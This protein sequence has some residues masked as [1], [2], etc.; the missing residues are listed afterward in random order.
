MKSGLLL[1]LAMALLLSSMN[2][3]ERYHYVEAWNAENLI[4]LHVAAHSDQAEDQEVKLKVKD[5]VV[6]ELSPALSEME[7]VREARV[8][9]SGYVASLEQNLQQMPELSGRAVQVRL[10]TEW[11]PH[12]RYGDIALPQG[13]YYALRVDIGQAQGANWWCLLFP[14]LCLVDAAVDYEMLPPNPGV[15]LVSEDEIERVPTRLRWAIW[16]YLQGL[17][18]WSSGRKP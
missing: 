9:L 17:G 12:R 8:Y 13:E 14:P 10:L 11:F 7:T 18:W 15:Q 2:W 6:E 5:A 3:A 1:V 16:E 4:R